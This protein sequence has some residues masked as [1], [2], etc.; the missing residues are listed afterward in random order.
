[1]AEVG[2]PVW[3]GW[4]GQSTELPRCCSGGGS[5]QEKGNVLEQMTMENAKWRTHGVKVVRAESLYVSMHE[6]AGKGRATAVDFSGTGGQRTWIGTVTLPPNA[7]TGAHHHGRHEVTVYVIK[8]RSE[9]RWGDKLEFATEVGPGDFVYF[10]PYVPH[11]ERNLSNSGPLDFVV[12][13]S[14]SEKIAVPLDVS[15][16]K[17]PEIVF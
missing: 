10:S 7:N 17:H 12:V 8:G 15:P 5:A 13:R 16:V 9:I 4:G 11:Q 2:Q 3:N 6:P 14:D 1:M